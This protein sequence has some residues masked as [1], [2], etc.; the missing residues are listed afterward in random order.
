MSENRSHMFEVAALNA[1]FDETSSE[2]LTKPVTDYGDRSVEADP[3]HEYSLYNRF[4]C[5]E[6]APRSI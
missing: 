4:S 5:S 3:I 1:Q 6:G 2:L